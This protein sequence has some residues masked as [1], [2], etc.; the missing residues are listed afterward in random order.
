MQLN[1]ADAVRLGFVLD[2]NLLD[3]NKYINASSFD[4]SITRVCP[5][6]LV[7]KTNLPCGA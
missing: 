3:D 2:R 6:A 4:L 5:S 1:T 7:K